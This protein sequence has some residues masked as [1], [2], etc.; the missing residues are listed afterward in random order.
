M[1]SASDLEKLKPY[2]LD[3][4][5]ADVTNKL[6]INFENKVLGAGRLKVERL[7]RQRAN[8]NELTGLIQR[9]VRDEQDFG[10][11]FDSHILFE[12]IGT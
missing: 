10:I 4:V 1:T 3:A 7:Q 5:P 6:D 2:I 8:V 11:G 9:L 12:L